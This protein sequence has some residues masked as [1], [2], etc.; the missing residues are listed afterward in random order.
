MIERGIT[1][2]EVVET[3]QAG[4]LVEIAGNRFIRRRVFDAG[5]DWN[6]RQFP[7]KDVTVVYVEEERRVVVLTAIARYGTWR[8]P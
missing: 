8:G 3:I 5:Y 2:H 7:E 4:Y 6:T 1:D